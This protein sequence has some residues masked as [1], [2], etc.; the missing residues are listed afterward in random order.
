MECPIIIIVDT[1]LIVDDGELSIHW[2]V[3]DPI[4]AGH[5]PG[6]DIRYEC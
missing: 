4:I 3:L 5:P 2:N 6:P 1:R